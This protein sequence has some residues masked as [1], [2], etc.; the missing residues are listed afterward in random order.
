MASDT[1]PAGQKQADIIIIGGGIAGAGAAYALAPQA[2]VILL[3]RENQPGYHTTGRS[4]ALFSETYGNAPIRA[5]TVASRDFLM[6]PPPG[7]CDG[8]ILTPR[9]VLQVG[10]AEKAETLDAAYDEMRRLVPSIR[11]LDAAAVLARVPVLRP[12]MVAAGA[13]A[14]PEAMDIDV[15]ALHRGFL[16]GAAAA[17]ASI[18]CDASVTGLARDTAGWRVDVAGQ[19]EY[20]AGIVINA[21]GAWADVTAALAGLGPLG[22]APKRRTALTAEMPAGLD[23]AAWPMVI[24]ADEQIY[25]K[26][27]AGRMLICPADETP[28]DPCD[29]QPDEMDIAI[30]VDRFETLTNLG[31]R[32]IAAKWAGLRSFFPDRTIVAGFDPQ[33]EGFFWLAGQGGYGIQ[34]SA[35]MSRVAGAL[36]LGRD[37]PSDIQE[38]GVSEADLSPSRFR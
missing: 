4:A 20:R 5:L 35:A 29:A 14:E 24:D 9:G 36:A 7:F 18:V 21:A 28:S 13:L 19:G 25:F 26:P 3:E 10:V 15:H 16:R 23:F 2:R 11:R 31:V 34:T 6:Q 27:E 33:A 38:L 1:Q 12:E 37:L 30:A 8:A 17:G 22:L 32:R